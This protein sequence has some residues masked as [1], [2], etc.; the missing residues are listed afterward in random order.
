M[1]EELILEGFNAQELTRGHTVP[2]AELG[3]DDEA[4]VGARSDEGPL[5][6]GN[7][8]V[9]VSISHDVPFFRSCV[10]RRKKP[11]FAGF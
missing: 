5:S 6:H 3:G 2:S 11:A 4:A 7:V 1:E 8:R 9:G 10:L